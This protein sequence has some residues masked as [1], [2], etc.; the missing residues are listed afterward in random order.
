MLQALPQALKLTGRWSLP[1]QMFVGVDE[2]LESPPPDARPPVERRRKNL[3]L[4]PPKVVAGAELTM[5]LTS[6]R[7]RD[8]MSTAVETWEGN[9]RHGKGKGEENVFV[10]GLDASSELVDR[11][12][13]SVD[14][15]VVDQDVE[16]MLLE[17]LPQRRRQS[18]LA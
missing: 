10:D 9:G 13:D 15:E 4:A 5:Y 16:E 3:Q 8:R 7:P 6:T 12:E 2:A 18:L 11:P 14:D 17:D 1:L